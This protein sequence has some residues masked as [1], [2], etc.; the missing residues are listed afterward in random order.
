MGSKGTRKG[1]VRSRGEILKK[2]LCYGVK[3][4]SRAGRKRPFKQQRLKR[5]VMRRELLI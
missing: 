5:G 3:T 2:I 4:S 1:S